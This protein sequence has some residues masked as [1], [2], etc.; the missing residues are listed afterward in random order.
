MTNSHRANRPDPDGRR[1][2]SGRG[3]DDNRAGELVSA[4]RSVGDGRASED[5]PPRSRSGSRHMVSPTARVRRHRHR[6]WVLSLLAGVGVAVLGGYAFGLLGPEPAPVVAPTSDAKPYI[7][8][9]AQ[10][11]EGKVRQ[12]LP[13]PQTFSHGANLDGCDRSYGVDNVCVPFNFPNGVGTTPAAKCAWL[14]Q[15]GFGPLE[16][17]GKDRQ[18]LVPAGGPKAPSGNPYACPDQLK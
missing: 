11:L 7:R 13:T 14:K 15:Q 10:E 16:V 8:E 4:Y 12:P 3:G 5:G 2:Q 1:R 17:P 18:N 6:P 9:Y